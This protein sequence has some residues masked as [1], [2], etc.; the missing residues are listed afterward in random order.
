M[1]DTKRT[2]LA[3][4]LIA[5][6]TLSIHFYL[7]LIGI[8]TND[9]QE[10]PSPAVDEKIDLTDP[11]GVVEPYTERSLFLNEADN[12]IFFT[13]AIKTNRFLASFFS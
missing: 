10:G 9:N 2:L 3:G 6:L 8:E 4:F 1:T 12:N 11:G 5:L 7:N 13:F